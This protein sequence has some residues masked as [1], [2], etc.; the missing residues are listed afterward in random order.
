[1]RGSGKGDGMS[2]T[3]S[4]CGLTKVKRPAPPPNTPPTP[5]VPFRPFRPM[6]LVRCDEGPRGVG[7]GDVPSLFLS[8]RVMCWRDC[9]SSVDSRELD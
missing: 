2:S 9:E 6:P 3:L 8:L 7:G 5:G 1:V 4:E